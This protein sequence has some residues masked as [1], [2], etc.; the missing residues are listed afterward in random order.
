[1]ALKKLVPGL[2]L[3]KI[4]SSVPGEPATP[5]QPLMVS[6]PPVREAL[7]KART[8]AGELVLRLITELSARVNAP[9]VWLALLAAKVPP[10]NVIAA[11]LL[12]AALVPS[13]RVPLLFKVTAV[14]D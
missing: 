1:M 13:D 2:L 5:L 14:L 6:V 8:P 12:I 3:I 10:L 4:V 7:A 9:K 11:G